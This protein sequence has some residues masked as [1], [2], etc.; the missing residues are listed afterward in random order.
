MYSRTPRDR[1]GAL[2]VI[3]ACLAKHPDALHPGWTV[4]ALIHLG[5]P[6]RALALFARGLT[7]DHGSLLTYLPRAAPRRGAYR[8]SR[9]SPATSGS[10]RCGIGSG[11]RMGAGG[12]RTGIIAADERR[13]RA[14]DAPTRLP[15][16]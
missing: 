15:P 14:R 2:A 13:S 5:E 12:I 10:P 7:T 6:A 4:T 3:D 16:E 11:R 9:R 8:S 1:A